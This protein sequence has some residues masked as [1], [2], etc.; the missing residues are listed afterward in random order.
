[1]DATSFG[2]LKE[3]LAETNSSPS[4]LSDEEPTARELVAASEIAKARSQ[5]SVSGKTHKYAKYSL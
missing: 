3:L 1:M 2:K 4:S 5:S